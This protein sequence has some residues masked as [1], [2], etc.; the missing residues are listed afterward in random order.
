MKNSL[1]WFLL[2]LITG[3]VNKLSVVFTYCFPALSSP[4]C[5]IFVVWH[6]SDVMTCVEPSCTE[7]DFMSLLNNCSPSLH[8]WSH[9][10][11]LLLM[12]HIYEQ[13]MS[14]IGGISFT[15]T[16]YLSPLLIRGAYQS[17]CKFRLGSLTIAEG[18]GKLPKARHFISLW[19]LQT[20]AFHWMLTKVSTH[21]L[22]NKPC[23]PL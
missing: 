8:Y 23:I 2:D 11:L 15:Q 21:Q 5:L 12:K 17:Y 9:F 1:I 19:W 22:S 20:W 18:H 16:S 13:N 7:H 3:G 14:V 6:S 10:H 4:S